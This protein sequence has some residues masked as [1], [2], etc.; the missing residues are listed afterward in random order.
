[1]FFPGSYHANWT[2]NQSL[3]NFP[4]L[5]Q[6]LEGNRRHDGFSSTHFIGQESLRMGDQKFDP[7]F[8]IGIKLCRETQTIRGCQQGIDQVPTGAIP[9]LKGRDFQRFF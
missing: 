9:D 7:Y 8:L 2:D 3:L 4:L 1:M 6:N 5:K